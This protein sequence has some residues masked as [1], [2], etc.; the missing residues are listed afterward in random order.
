LPALD[1]V[2]CHFTS[3]TAPHV[4]TNTESIKEIRVSTLLLP[5]SPTLLTFVSVHSLVSGEK[6]S[7]T[8][9][10][11]RADAET[12]RTAFMILVQAIAHVSIQVRFIDLIGFFG[13]SHQCPQD[14]ATRW[15]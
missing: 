11:G 8:L 2:R 14:M 7:G 3:G 4:S 12:G 9:L 10:P 6:A 1:V 5:P 15:S 13:S